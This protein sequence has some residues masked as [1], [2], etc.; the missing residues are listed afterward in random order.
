MPKIAFV[1][2]FVSISASKFQGV[3]TLLF[4]AIKHCCNF[5]FQRFRTMVGEMAQWLKGLALQI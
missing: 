5:I 4:V 1:H 2:G 3:A